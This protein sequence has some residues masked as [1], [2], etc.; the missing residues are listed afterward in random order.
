VRCI[1][2]QSEANLSAAVTRGI[3]AGPGFDARI[4]GLHRHRV[5]DPLALAGLRI[6]SPS[7]AVLAAM[8]LVSDHYDVLA[9]R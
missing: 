3:Q 9:L 6:H 8:R 2:T 4:A 7:E 5:E 1:T